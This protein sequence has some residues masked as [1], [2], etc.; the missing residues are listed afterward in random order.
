MLI[1]LSI[2][3]SFFQAFLCIEALLSEFCGKYSFPLFSWFMA[4]AASYVNT[5]FSLVM[6][7]PEWSACIIVKADLISAR[8]ALYVPPLISVNLLWG[9]GLYHYRVAVTTSGL[10]E[11]FAAKI[12]L[13]R[14]SGISLGI[15]LKLTGNLL[16]LVDCLIVSLDKKSSHVRN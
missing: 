8:L 13:I 9:L 2:N 4:S 1:Q 3:V 6:T 16:Q 10:I 5:F 7:F 12:F 14:S 11:P 15:F